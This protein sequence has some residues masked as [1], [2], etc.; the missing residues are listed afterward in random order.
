MSRKQAIDIAKGSQDIYVLWFELEIDPMY[1]GRAGIDNVPP[2]YLN[3]RFEIYT[4]GTGKTKTG[5]SIYQR[6]RTPGG[7][8][9]PGGALGSAQYLLRNAGREMADRVFDALGLSRPPD[10]H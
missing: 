9:V 8:P 4:P 7:L 1:Q 2:Q 6:S 3:V 10:R 5:G